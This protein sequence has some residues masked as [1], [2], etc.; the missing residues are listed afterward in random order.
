[1]EPSKSDHDQSEPSKSGHDQS[2]PIEFVI[3]PYNTTFNYYDSIFDI[4]INQK[5]EFINEQTNNDLLTF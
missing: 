3:D 4:L 1:M 5:E 2:E